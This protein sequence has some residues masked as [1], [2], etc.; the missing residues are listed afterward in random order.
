[1]PNTNDQQP[2]TV[3]WIWQQPQWP[4]FY[5]DSEFLAEPLREANL[6]QSKL[7]GRVGAVSEAEGAVSELDALLR[8]I[9]ESSAIEGEV[10][11]AESVR[12]SLAKRLG[13]KEAGL[14]RANAQTE[15]LA[16]LMLD[17]TQNHHQALSLD[18]LFQWHRHLFP[19]PS[20]GEF[21]LQTVVPGQLRGDTTMQVVSGPEQRRKVHF[22]APPREALEEELG[23]F[24]KWFSDSRSD[25]KLDPILRAAQAHFWFVTLHPFEDGNGRL[26]RAV[27]DHALAQ[28]ENQAIRFYAMAASIMDN[29]NGYYDILESSQKGNLDITAW[30]EWFLTT[31]KHALNSALDRIDFVLAK[32]RFWQQHGQAGLNKQQVKV[33]NRLLDAG[34]GGFEG[35]L[36]AAKYKGIAGVSKATATRHLVDLLEKGCIY[37]KEGGGRSTRYELNWP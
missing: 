35:G 31:L 4:S 1:M 12:S 33:L 23:I 9:V 5:W 25:K 36:S 17:A 37:K 3:K 15:G 14:S 26:A 28:A 30:M 7:L 20:E 21:V 2:A 18:R 19:E 29:R 34:P 16:D 24:L 8:N 22:E 27:S 10:L 32:A 13:V 11:N 6:I